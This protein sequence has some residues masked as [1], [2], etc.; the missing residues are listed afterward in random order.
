MA[1]RKSLLYLIAISLLVLLGYSIYRTKSQNQERH[2][3]GIDVI[4]KQVE[5]AEE[6]MGIEDVKQE[7]HRKGFKLEGQRIDTIDVGQ[8]ERSLRENPLF[9]DVEVYITTSGRMQVEVSQ[10]KALFLVQQGKNSYY[11]SSER[12]VIPMNPNYAVYVPIVT[13]TVSQEE[14]TGHI[15]DLIQYIKQNDYLCNYFDHI[16]VDS[17]EGVILSPRIGQTLVV[18]GRN[19]NY[20][21]MFHKYRLFVEEVAPRVSPNTYAYVKLGYNGQVVAGRTSAQTEPESPKP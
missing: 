2:L 18:L 8:I 20:E 9:S 12:G 4:L 10:K 7:L 3:A 14:A 15:Y 11:V 17:V 13:G 19:Q 6:F 16:Y 5:G 1:M 21:E